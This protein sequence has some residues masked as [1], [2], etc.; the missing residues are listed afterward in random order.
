MP[1][2]RFI[3]IKQSNSFSVYVKNL[4]ELSINQVHNIE[5]FVKIRQGY[6]NFETYTF[7]IYKKLEYYEFV[8]L[9]D[10]LHVEVF[11]QE[12]ILDI[13]SSAKKCKL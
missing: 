12:D 9:L 2:P 13:Q 4:E 11:L 7:A 6:F 8:K 10:L 3:F 1:K 5:T